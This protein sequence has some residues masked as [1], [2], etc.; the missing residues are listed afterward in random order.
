MSDRAIKQFHLTLPSRMRSLLPILHVEPQRKQS[1]ENQECAD[2]MSVYGS[3]LQQ[4]F[5]E[6]ESAARR[7]RERFVRPPI[8]HYTFFR[9]VALQIPSRGAVVI[10]DFPVFI[11]HTVGT[12]SRTSHGLIYLLMGIFCYFFLLVMQNGSV[13]MERYA[14][15]AGTRLADSITRLGPDDLILR[16]GENVH[17]SPPTRNILTNY[18]RECLPSHPIPFSDS[19]SRVCSK[20][21][22]KLTCWSHRAQYCCG[23]NDFFD[24]ATCESSKV[25]S[26]AVAPL[27]SSSPGA[28]S[29]LTRSSDDGGKAAA[30]KSPASLWSVDDVQAF[31]EDTVPTCHAAML[32]N[33]NCC[34]HLRFFYTIFILYSLMRLQTCFL[35]YS[36]FCEYIFKKV[37]F[38]SCMADKALFYFTVE[39]LRGKFGEKCDGY[40]NSF[41]AEDIDGPAALLSLKVSF[42]VRLDVMT[43]SFAT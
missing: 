1:E 24:L 22:K 11:L 28:A 20:A 38:V 27:H 8:S 9:I 31:G 10:E 39:R 7:D 33:D 4:E 21:A 16:I 26:D 12:H 30:G 2:H 43:E 41:K 35:H 14:T 34:I 40:K 42:A 25:S 13:R 6:M 23:H 29:S 18:S 19:V 32:R 17:R 15:S 5:E 36:Q 37:R 3:V